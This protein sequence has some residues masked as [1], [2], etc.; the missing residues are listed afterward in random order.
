MI[1]DPNQ[2]VDITNYLPRGVQHG[3]ELDII[4][5]RLQK[6]GWNGRAAAL[7]HGIV[8][9]R[10]RKRQESAAGLRDRLGDQ[11][12]VDLVAPRVRQVYLHI[13]PTNSGKTFHALQRLAAATRGLYL[14]PL[15]LLAWEAA[16]RLNEAGCPTDLLTGE[17]FVPAGG[18]R[19]TAATTEMFPQGVY[20][21][22][23]VDEAQMVGDPE[24]GWAWLRALVKANAAELHV[25]AAPHAE[26][27]LQ[28]LFAILGDRVEARR[29]E[30][31]TPLRPHATAMSLRRLPPRSAVVA[32]SRAGVLRLKAEIETMHRKPCAVIY[33]ALPPD[34]RREQAR[35]LRSGE[36]PF[37]V[38]TDAIGMGINFPVDHVFL[39]EVAKFDGHQERP[40]YPAEILQIIGRAGRFGLSE[41]GWYGALSRENHHYLLAAAQEP[42]QPIR[43][44]YLQPTVEQLEM[45][46]GRL[47]KRLQLWQKLAEP[48]VPELVQ[49]APLEQMVDL[50]R[51]LPPNL[52]EDLG[53]AYM[54]VT[55]PVA[56]ESL[57]YWQAV[58]GAL[59]AGRKAPYPERALHE[60]RSDAELQEAEGA[61]KQHELCLW[62]I[63]RGVPCRAGEH[64]VRGARDQIAAAINH[65]L[66]RGIA[67]AGCRTCGR[68]L[69]SGSRFRI[70]DLCY[71]A[72]AH[73]DAGHPRKGERGT[74]DPRK[75]PVRRF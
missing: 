25:C 23:V 6:L 70:C 8:K 13:G 63:R 40:L 61:L 41:T 22:V 28:E 50:A 57:V 48:A 31:L 20:E 21:V 42:P 9:T 62:L 65:A 14:A 43:F 69:P 10:K 15:R 37:V 72:R 39:W 7:P 60:I 35:R 59:A 24:R 73:E 49:I 47:H 18:A 52:E 3:E 44:A 19:V 54:L 33:G 46:H 16:D 32:F 38:A 71:E 4:L 66:T 2:S 5:E 64:R 1:P 45:M 56:R 30:R 34:V 75:R 36:S 11:I 74:A 29:Y 68:K 17:E 12:A 26:G 53:R 58:V 67:P 27:F 51:M 55:A